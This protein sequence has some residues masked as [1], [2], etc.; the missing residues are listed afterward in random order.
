MVTNLLLKGIK[1]VGSRPIWLKD[2]SNYKLFIQYPDSSKVITSET[3]LVQHFEITKPGFLVK[4]IKFVPNPSQ[5]TFSWNKAPNDDD[6]FKYEFL[7][8][9][10]Y[11]E[12]TYDNQVRNKELILATGDVYPQVGVPELFY[13]YLR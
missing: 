1:I 13:N 7:L 11:Q 6:K 10:N 4:N 12:L 8:I 5:T 3:I 9:F 2:K